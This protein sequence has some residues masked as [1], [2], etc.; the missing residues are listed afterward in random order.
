MR[1]SASARANALRVLLRNL[2][3]AP[4]AHRPPEEEQ[5]SQTECDLCFA[6]DAEPK[7]PL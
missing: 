6:R 2:S 7:R 4:E 1:N 3:I 5:D